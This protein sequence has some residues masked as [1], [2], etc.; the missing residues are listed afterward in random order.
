MQNFVNLKYPISLKYSFYIFK[1]W[2]IL[3]IL[4]HVFNGMYYNTL[5]DKSFNFDL[6]II[7]KRAPLNWCGHNMRVQPPFFVYYLVESLHQA[8]T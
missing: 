6:N 5:F 4:I 1:K 7:P 3:F 2:Y 8:V